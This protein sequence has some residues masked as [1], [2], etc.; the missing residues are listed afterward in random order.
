MESKEEEAEK[1]IK[2]FMADVARDRQHYDEFGSFIANY[3]MAEATVHCAVRDFSGLDDRR[4]RIVF[5]GM[6]LGDLAERLRKL[7][8]PKAKI[9]RE[10][11]ACLTQLAT[12]AK[13]R[14]KL[15]HRTTNIDPK[16][17]FKV[18]NRMTVA[19]LMN[20]EEE[21]FDIEKLRNMQWD[22]IVIGFRLLL[23]REQARPGPPMPPLDKFVKQSAYGPWRYK[24]RQPSPK[25]KAHRGT[26]RSRKR[27]RP[28]SPG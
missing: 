17:G 11:D 4:A 23:L 21:I 13:E 12:I 26:L 5:S 25:R 7:T 3:A 18:S 9:Y 6:R 15:I 19:S 8:R 2:K 1:V 20:V 28:S 16:G 27:Q 14:H 22:C 24:S 10:V